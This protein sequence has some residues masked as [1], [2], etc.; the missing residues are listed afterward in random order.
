MIAQRFRCAGFQMRWNA[1]LPSAVHLWIG[2]PGPQISYPSQSHRFGPSTTLMPPFGY[3]V[4][5]L[6]LECGGSLRIRDDP[7]IWALCHFGPCI[8]SS[9]TEPC[10]CAPSIVS[11]VSEDCLIMVGSASPRTISQPKPFNPGFRALTT[12]RRGGRTSSAGD[13]VGG[14]LGFAMQIPVE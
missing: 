7:I 13:G 12:S 11:N 10:V 9:T 1:W 4:S 6:H 8:R 3:R 14:R 2:V 5:D